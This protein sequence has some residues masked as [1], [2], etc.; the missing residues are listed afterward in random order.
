MLIS[1]E[2]QN[3]DRMSKWWRCRWRCVPPVLWSSIC[4]CDSS[5]W[6]FTGEQVYACW[7]ERRN[8][9]RLVFYSG[10]LASR[11]YKWGT[12]KYGISTVF[13]GSKTNSQ[14]SSYRAQGCC[15]GKE[16]HWRLMLI[17]GK[18]F[19]PDSYLYR[20]HRLIKIKAKISNISAII[21]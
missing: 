14:A 6:V 5:E 7:L 8:G 11:S 18:I 13:R 12:K 3:K 20:I 16:A 2:W 17:L 10:K 9:L 19:E 1:L 4:E 21:K 15:F